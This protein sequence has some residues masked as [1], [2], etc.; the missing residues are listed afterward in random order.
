MPTFVHGKNGYLQLD[1]SSDSLVDL[2]AYCDDI[3]FPQEVSADETTTFGATD[4][5]YIVGLGD[6]KLSFS[7]KLDATLDSHMQGVIAALKAGTLTTASGV[8][9]PAGSASGKIKYTFESIVTSY[10]VSE[11]VSDV[12]EFKAELQITGTVTRTTF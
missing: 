8:F 4:K 11:K 6:A 3:S 1:N 12:A 9:G 10:E 7:G 5:S 2:S